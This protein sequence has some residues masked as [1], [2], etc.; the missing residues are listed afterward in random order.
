MLLVVVLWF[1][2]CC[3]VLMLLFV[4]DWCVLYA[5]VGCFDVVVVG[6]LAIVRCCW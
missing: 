6:R 1:V 4:S 2:A 5:V 3:V